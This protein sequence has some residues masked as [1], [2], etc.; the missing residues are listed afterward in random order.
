MGIRA[1][2]LLLLAAVLGTNRSAA[3][4][5]PA[6]LED[7]VKAAFVFNFIKFI[8]WP[9]NAFEKADTPIV[10]E[11]LGADGIASAME[12]GVRDKQVNKRPLIV[13]RLTRVEEIGD[14]SACHLLFVGRSEQARMAEISRR[15]EKAGVVT[16]ADSEGFL[17][18]GGMI[19]FV[20]EAKRLQFE[21]NTVAAER[22]GLKIS[23]QLLKL[24]IRVAP[25]RSGKGE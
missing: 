18:Q 16:V 23:S 25:A 24:A 17:D 3:Q 8:E 5:D 2:I 15:L 4:A 14:G 7:K 12:D 20:M 19:N 6:L 1:G 10:V 21:V 13:R 9:S 22:A 11:V